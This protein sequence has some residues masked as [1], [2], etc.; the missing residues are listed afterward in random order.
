MAILRT[1]KSDYEFFQHQT[2]EILVALDA[3]NRKLLSNYWKSNKGK[4]KT[5]VPQI[6]VNGYKLILDEEFETL[7]I[8]FSE[9]F[10]FEA[11]DLIKAKMQSL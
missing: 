5:T 8:D 10:S 6:Q 11:K 1:I 3:E 4:K 7:K 9:L 2:L